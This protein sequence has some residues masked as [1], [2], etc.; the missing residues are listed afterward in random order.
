MNIKL[1]LK[2]FAIKT[3]MVHLSECLDKTE[4]IYHQMAE[5]IITLLRNLV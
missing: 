3:L 5:L 1:N 4:K 2:P